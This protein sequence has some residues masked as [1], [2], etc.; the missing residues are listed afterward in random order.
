M[1][2]EVHALEMSHATDVSNGG[3]SIVFV[4]RLASG[5]WAST[6]DHRVFYIHR[7]Q[8]HRVPSD[9]IRVFDYHGSG[10]TDKGIA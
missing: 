8:S 3:K 10:P 5:C 7:K 9:G 4:R 6:A 2:V 1:V